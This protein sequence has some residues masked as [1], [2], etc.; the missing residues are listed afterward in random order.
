M[1]VFEIQIL[2]NLFKSSFSLLKSMEKFFL[3]ILVILL[4]GC[5]SKKEDN[6]R[7]ILKNKYLQVVA[8]K[9][10]AELI[11]IKL[12]EDDTEYLWQGDSITWS[13]HAIVQ[14]PIIGNLKKDKYS[15]SNEIYTM[16]SHGFARVS[17]FEIIEKS[18][19]VVV[20]QLKS[21]N[22]TK[23]LYPFEFNFQ[24]TYRLENKSIKV[25][26]DVLNKDD[27]EM[28]FS[29]GYHPG[30][31][32]PFKTGE[33]MEDY[34]LEFSQKESV[35]R[36]LLKDNLIDTVKKN[37]LSSVSKILLSKSIFKYDAIIL[38]NIA[39]RSTSL[40]NKLND[41][42]VKL[43]FG[44]VPYLG[45]WS[46]KKYGDFVCIEPWFGIADS[47][48]SNGILK[49]KEGIIRLSKQKIYHWECSIT[50]N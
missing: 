12:L 23:A 21:N 3:L 2:S 45:I 24:I 49:D 14:F 32:C 7:V 42:S 37:Y 29:L 1:K 35:D 25:L 17:D 46:T 40:K 6:Q 20:F 4:I 18:D 47:T 44:N 36:L 33:K 9:N 22:K 30:F 16:M 39:S 10:G 43:S 50:I 41:K 34:Y 5:T 11:S 28:Y 8:K 26:F 15:Y 13:D 38:K 31:N 48:D 27:K 19:D